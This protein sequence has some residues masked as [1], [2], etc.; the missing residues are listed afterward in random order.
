MIKVIGCW[1]VG[2]MWLILWPE[3][4]MMESQ[5]QSPLYIKISSIVLSGVLGLGFMGLYH[6]LRIRRT[7]KRGKDYEGHVVRAHEMQLILERTELWN[8]IK[9]W[10]IP[11]TDRNQVW[12]GRSLLT[13]KD[14]YLNKEDLFK[15]ILVIGS[16]GT[17]KTARYMKTVAK[18]LLD[19]DKSSF[20]YFA[21]KAEDAIEFKDWLK[22]GGQ[23]PLCWSMSSLVDLTR[24]PSGA[25]EPGRFTALVEGAMHA[26]GHLSNDK[27]WTSTFNSHLLEHVM[28][29]SMDGS[30][31]FGSAYARYAA[32][33]SGKPNPTQL[34]Q[35]LLATGRAIFQ[36][37]ASPVSR[38]HLL[39]APS[40][41]G[42]HVGPLY[43][44][45]GHRA[46]NLQTREIHFAAEAML[47]PS[48]V[49]EVPRG[50]R[51]PWTWDLMRQGYSFILPP[52]GS[53]SSAEIFALNL[54]K[55][56][57]FA[58]IAEDVG[59]PNS[60]LLKRDA[61]DRHRLIFLQDEGHNFVTLEGQFN[62]IMALQQFRQAGL[63]NILASQSFSAFRK[64]KNAEINDNFF[65][66]LGCQIYLSVQGKERESVIKTIGKC[67]MKRLE[68][69]YSRSQRHGGRDAAMDD[70]GN[71]MASGPTVSV[72]ENVREIETEFITAEDFKRLPGGVSVCVRQE[73]FDDVIFCP[74][75]DRV[76]FH[77]VGKKAV[78]RK[79]AC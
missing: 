33:I 66:N 21:L 47:L 6:A 38:V 43:L 59:S 23:K 78:E 40:P 25:I 36:D 24:E 48:G 2:L 62:D 57:A 71:L 65:A 53:A 61:E 68:R 54:I 58:W 17:G 46:R 75:H 77:W 56:S 49:Y 26:L 19:D 27:F 3:T 9:S 11:R 4:W 45:R 35:S 52:P 12:I 51:M 16:A 34:E 18:Q 7:T 79:E 1:T 10:K 70:A 32:T 37:Y 39:Y 74:Y 13:G 67:R 22:D 50:G 73:H 15:G 44:A 31:D 42:V 28:A 63:V 8:A 20:L 76:H 69:N 55:Q 29:L 72:A 5:F 14:V 64:S 60:Q 41:G 30:A